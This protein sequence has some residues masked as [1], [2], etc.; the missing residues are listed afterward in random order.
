M[1]NKKVAVSIKLPKKDA[2]NYKQFSSEES[3]MCWEII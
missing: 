3:F 2:E 1:K